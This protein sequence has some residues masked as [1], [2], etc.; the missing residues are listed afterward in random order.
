M[1][2]TIISPE[3]RD[4]LSSAFGM[5]PERVLEIVRVHCLYLNV[6]ESL[7]LIYKY[8]KRERERERE[9]ERDRG[10]PSLFTPVNTLQLL[11]VHTCEPTGPTIRFATSFS[12]KLSQSLHSSKHD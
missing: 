5:L 12:V 2:V 9:R 7:L 4:A 6:S 8:V 3:H 10:V 1:V 11:N